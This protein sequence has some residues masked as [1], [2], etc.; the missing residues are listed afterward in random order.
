MA[1]IAAMILFCRVG[2]ATPEI[3][4][5]FG[6]VT[7]IEVTEPYSGSP[8]FVDEGIFY[9]EISPGIS[10]L[11]RFNS[12][13]IGP[14]FRYYHAREFF[15]DF[16]ETTLSGF[17]AGAEFIYNYKMTE[18][19]EWLFPMSLACKHRWIQLT[20]ETEHKAY[21]ID[22]FGWGMRAMLG[23]ERVFADRYSVGILVGRGLLVDKLS[24]D[25]ISVH[26]DL[27]MNGWRFEIF[28]RTKLS[29]QRSY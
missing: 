17:A 29:P 11:W 7:T 26:P 10:L 19:G 18:T 3:K 24:D 2:S 28:L 12:F 20:Y 25:G 16:Q 5:G 23:V 22:G 4:A 21:E 1:I 14:T 6:Y 15:A 8:L 13:S 9:D 27:M